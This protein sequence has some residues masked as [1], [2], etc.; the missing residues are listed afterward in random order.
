MGLIAETLDAYAKTQ[1]VTF[2][3]DRKQ[4]MGASEVGQCARKVFWLKNEDDPEHAVPRDPEYR[5]TWGARMRGTVY[6]ACF[7]EPAMRARFRKRLHFAGKQ[8]RTF[9][10]GFLTATPDGMIW[11]LLVDEKPT[12]IHSQCVLVECKT[13]DPRTNLNEAKPPKSTRRRCRW[14]WCARARI[15][16]DT[17]HH[18]LHRR[19]V[20]ERRQGVRRRVRSRH[21]SGRVERARLV[22]TA[23][24]PPRPSPRGGSR[25]VRN[26]TTAHS[27]NHAAWSAR[28]LPFRDTSDLQFVAEMTTWR[29]STSRLSAGAT[30]RRPTRA[31]WRK[32]SRPACVRKASLKYPGF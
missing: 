1:T 25:G 23:T 22:M 11:P 31:P 21:L 5:D 17:R 12:G 15:S 6:E 29:G 28:N 26:A 16:A 19:L 13:A 10:K 3:H 8:Q 27:P 20:L 2:K 14:A 32:K 4:T 7:W 18:Q 30:M 9:N 24:E